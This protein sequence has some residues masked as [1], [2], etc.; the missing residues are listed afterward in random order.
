VQVDVGELLGDE[1]EQAGLGEAFELGEEVEA[2]EDVAG[3]RR[4][5]LDVG[6]EVLAQVVLVAAVCEVQRRGVV[7]AL[8]GLAQQE[9]VGA[10]AGL[11]LGVELGEHRRLGAGQHAVEA[12]Q[13][14]EGQDDLA[15]LGL[16]V[17][18]AEEVGDGPDEGREGL[19]VHGSGGP[20]REGRAGSRRRRDFTANELFAGRPLRAVPDVVPAHSAL[21]HAEW[22]CSGRCAPSIL[23]LPLQGSVT[24]STKDGAGCDMLLSR[25]AAFSSADIA[26]P[27]CVH[28]S[29]QTGRRPRPLHFSSGLPGC[30]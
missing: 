16:F 28:S 17:V 1:V 19:V 20:C 12:A 4:E 15:V 22:G 8:P 3:G 21:T 23:G 6:V 27:F 25:S 2:L 9:G 14:R 11:G 13:H 24:S 30:A 10:D 5:A 26:P 7:E 18:A 29:T